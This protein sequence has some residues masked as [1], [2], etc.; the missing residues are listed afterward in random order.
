MLSLEKDLQTLEGS[1]LIRLAATYP[2]LEYWFR[3]ALVQETTYQTLV[4]PDRKHLHRIVGEVLE[5]A[6]DGHSALAPLLAHH[7]DQAGD[8]SR[9]QAYYLLAGDNAARVYANA[10]A[11][12]HYTRAL[13]VLSQSANPSTA[14]L[15]ELYSKRGR[16]LE[17][18]GQYDQAL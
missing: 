13:E 6:S 16:A 14:A 9:A 4:R 10:E 8:E 15:N 1:G 11:S 12:A 18:S 17:L 7:F 5:R 3:H 2:D